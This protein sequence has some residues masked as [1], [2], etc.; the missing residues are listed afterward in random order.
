MLR[1]AELRIRQG[2]FDETDALF[3][4]AELPPFKSL[5][6]DFCLLGRAGMA[7]AQND[8]ETAIDLAER[9]LR[10]VPWENRMERL[11]GLELLILA[12]AARGDHA[13]AATALAELQAAT[14]GLTTKPIRA[15]VCFA[16]GVVAAATE[17]FDAARRCFEDAVDCWSASGSPYE[18]ALAQLELARALFA[19]GRPQ[20]AEQQAR[21]ALN[22]LQSLGA[23]PDV[24]RATELVRQIE[25]SATAPTGAT[26]HRADLTAREMGILR[27]IAA[28][29][30]NQEIAQS[31]VLSVRTVERHISNI[32]AKLGVS[33]A[34]ARAAVVAHAHR[35]GVGISSTR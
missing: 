33:G 6:S 25:S 30:S 7:L 16:K 35:Y 34:S 3:A 13:R 9:F 27:L 8:A 15:S 28:G 1:L 26:A 17:D 19:L 24:A 11:G 10:A 32:Y 23:A 5:A 12:H 2:R 22:V 21:A 29:K 4:R 18:A 31:L 20:P 14:A